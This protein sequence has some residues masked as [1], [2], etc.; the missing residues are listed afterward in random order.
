VR[1]CYWLLGSRL[2]GSDDP[3]IFQRCQAEGR[4]LITLDLDFSNVPAYPPA[5]HAGIVVIRSKIQDK[6]I[7]LQLLARLIPVLLERSPSHQLWIV[8]QD[9]VR[10][11]EA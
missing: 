10:F 7:L 6:L 4:I 5:S 1:N 3:T 11:R 9:R 8:E 2:S